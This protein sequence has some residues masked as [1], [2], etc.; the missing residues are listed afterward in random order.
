MKKSDIL[1][2]VVLDTYSEVL[3]I[4]EIDNGSIQI[5]DNNSY[6]LEKDLSQDEV[7]FRELEIILQLSCSPKDLVDFIMKY[8]LEDH[9]NLRT[10]KVVISK[11]MDFFVTNN[12]VDTSVLTEDITILL[13]K[14]ILKYARSFD[15][16]IASY[17]AT[18]SKEEID[19]LSENIETNEKINAELIRS[20]KKITLDNVKYTKLVTFILTSDE[21]T[22][23]EY[24]E[25]KIKKH[26]NISRN[27]IETS[28][29]I[30]SYLKEQNLLNIDSTS[31]ELVK[32]YCD[33]DIVNKMFL[34]L[35]CF[36]YN[37]KNIQNKMLEYIIL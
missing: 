12:I 30:S 5:D 35:F 29:K 32:K 25:K 27:I 7:I 24:F 20:I 28:Y 8:N 26:K 15:I 19:T 4:L 22:I 1:N 36:S 37:I 10:S 9:I 2:L 33:K 18:L 6:E 34:V 3:S 23:L 11:I 16:F 21:T 17:I 14:S 13:I 31:L